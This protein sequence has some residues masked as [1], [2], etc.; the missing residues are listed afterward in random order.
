[1]L[2]R[3]H[4]RVL[5]DGEGEVGTTA[6]DTETRPDDEPTE[7]TPGRTS[8][9][10]RN[11]WLL[12][13]TALVAIAAVVAVLVVTGDEDS[14]A[15]GPNRPA[16]TAKPVELTAMPWS[17]EAEQAPLPQL[18]DDTVLFF[19]EIDHEE[20]MVLADART[21]GHR[22]IQALDEDL[23]GGG[24]RVDALSRPLLVTHST[25][26][27]VL[28]EY[29]VARCQGNPGGDGVALLSA[30]DGSMLW[31]TPTVDGDPRSTDNTAETIIETTDD[32]TV[33]VTIH[34]GMARQPGPNELRVLALDVGTGAIRWEARDVWP[35][36]IAGDV[37]LGVTG[38]MLV[39]TLRNAVGAPLADYPGSVSALDL[40]TG[41]P[42]WD[43]TDRA[44]TSQ[45][46]AAAG[47][48]ALVFGNDG[49]RQVVDVRTGRELAEFPGVWNAEDCAGS[50]DTTLIA[51]ATHDGRAIRTFDTADRSTQVTVGELG[52]GRDGV[53]AGTAWRDRI[54]DWRTSRTFDRAGN[55]VDEELPGVI[56]GSSGDLVLTADVEPSGPGRHV[57]SDVAVYQ[58]SR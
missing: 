50:V 26:L 51:C 24:L 14:G 58:V 37:V 39:P 12:A 43:F 23:P 41:R 1:M 3:Q 15:P 27:A 13:G 29:C 7:P 45:L 17:P 55:R 54:L 6:D 8:V 44:R 48:A 49:V 57:V 28:V 10:W 18:R 52:G 19:E 2:R 16:P 38:D 46:V 40:A 9:P 34:P 47:D 22:W 33:L 36:R 32:D 42:L 4:G 31:R 21:G 25:G 20:H 30:K 5:T 56:I 11:P 35:V 53:T